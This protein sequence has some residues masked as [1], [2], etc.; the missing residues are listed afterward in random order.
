MGEGVGGVSENFE[1]F[2][3]IRNFRYD[4]QLQHGLL[5]RQNKIL[6][7]AYGLHKNNPMHTIMPNS[8]VEFLKKCNLTQFPRVFLTP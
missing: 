2:L 1:N 5:Q 3:C 8:P 4:R 7:Y 6:M